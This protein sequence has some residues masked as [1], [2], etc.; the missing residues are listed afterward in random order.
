MG[1]GKPKHSRSRLAGGHGGPQKACCLTSSAPEW[2]EGSEAARLVLDVTVVGFYPMPT[3]RCRVVS[4][5]QSTGVVNA[6]EFVGSCHDVDVEMLPL[7]PFL[8]QIL[9]DFRIR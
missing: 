3:L 8:G 9:I 1:M 5:I 4:G 2:S 6:Q 7:R